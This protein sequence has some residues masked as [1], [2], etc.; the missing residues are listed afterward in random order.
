VQSFDLT[1]RDGVVL[2]PLILAIIAF[3]VYPQLALDSGE[4]AVKATVQ[5]VQR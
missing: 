4:E 2:V 3:A 5:A 1:V